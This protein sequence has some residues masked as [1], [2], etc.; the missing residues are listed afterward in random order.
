M[1]PR[2]C[3]RSAQILHRLHAAAKQHV[4]I[5]RPRCL[6]GIEQR[7]HKRALLLFGIRTK[8][9]V[10]GSVEHL[11][12]RG[13]PRTTHKRIINNFPAEQIVLSKTQLGALHNLKRRLG[14]KNRP[15][16]GILWHQLMELRRRR[17]KLRRIEGAFH[18]ARAIKTVRRRNARARLIGGGKHHVL[19]NISTFGVSAQVEGAAQAIAARSVRNAVGS[20]TFARNIRQACRTRPHGSI[21]HGSASCGQTCN[22]SPPWQR[23]LSRPIIPHRQRLS[24]RSHAPVPTSPLRFPLKLLRCKSQ[25]QHLRRNR[26]FERQIEVLA[27]PDKRRIGPSKRHKHELVARKRGGTELRSAVRIEHALIASDPHRAIS[28]I[29]CRRQKTRTY[30]V[31][32]KARKHLV[33]TLCAQQIAQ[34][35]RQLI[36]AQCINQNAVFAQL[37]STLHKRRQ[38]HAHHRKLRKQRRI[39]LVERLLAKRRKFCFNIRLKIHSGPFAHL[40][41]HIGFIRKAPKPSSRVPCAICVMRCPHRTLPHATRN[42]NI[43]SHSR[44][45]NS[46]RKPSCC[47]CYP[48]A[49]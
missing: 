10:R 33:E 39:K 23:A 24:P 22:K 14:I 40:C 2:T 37:V 13:K 3:C 45:I 47:I 41:L 49:V 29:H 26:A 15:N 17:F 46:T 30:L 28:R 12:R 9:L 42:S 36:A 48:S 8:P 21:I 34:R 38:L 19:R 6:C 1:L 18:K 16:D 7:R 31:G 4:H 25:P 20:C 11:R 27:P 44:E 32:N 5:Q 43:V 35:K